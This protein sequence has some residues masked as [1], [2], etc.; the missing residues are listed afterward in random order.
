MMFLYL[1]AFAQ[2][3]RCACDVVHIVTLS[4]VRSLR[5]K[6]EVHST[7]VQ[8]ADSLDGGRCVP[9]WFRGQSS[10]N[11]GRAGVAVAVAALGALA[12]GRGLF[13]GLF[14]GSASASRPR[15]GAPGGDAPMDGGEP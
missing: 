15:P 12:V 13:G 11:C 8:H 3:D 9:C 5:H 6:S 14:G 7:N 1:P 4:I 2:Q 10:N